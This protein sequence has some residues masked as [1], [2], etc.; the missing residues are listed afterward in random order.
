MTHHMSV[1][2]SWY[3]GSVMSSSD[4][5][6]S[7]TEPTEPNRTKR[8][9]YYRV[10]SRLGMH[11]FPVIL[12]SASQPPVYLRTFHSWHYRPP[13]LVTVSVASRRLSV[14]PPAV[15]LYWTTLSSCLSSIVSVVPSL[16]CHG[17][18]ETSITIVNDSL[19]EYHS[20]AENTVERV[21]WAVD[22]VGV[23]CDL[24]DSCHQLDPV[25]TLHSFLLVKVRLDLPT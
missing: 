12:P 7:R 15:T 6:S 14:I 2:C 16:P 18:T 25:Q 13:I 3:T 8:I 20:V 10:E 5:S 11:Y 1:F 21:V 19:A 24:I 23:T 9:D 17:V 4:L 22:R